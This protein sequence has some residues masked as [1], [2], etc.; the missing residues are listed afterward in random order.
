MKRPYA[1]ISV[2]FGQKPFFFNIDAMMLVSITDYPII[3]KNYAHT[4]QSERQKITEQTSHADVSNLHPTLDK[5]ELCKALVAQY[6]SHDGYVET[7][8]AFAGEVRTEATS[9]RGSP[10]SRLEGYL[11]VEEDHDAMHRQRMFMKLLI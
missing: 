2:N 6:L 8:R 11:S 3:Q 10:D 7:V 9:L 1:Q 4:Q 5:D